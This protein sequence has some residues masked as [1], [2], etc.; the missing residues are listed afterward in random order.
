MN[1]KNYSN[2]EIKWLI[3]EWEELHGKKGTDGGRLLLLL[4]MADISRCMRRLSRKEREAVL[5]CGVLGIS[6]RSAAI[7]VGVSSPQTMN[8]RYRHGLASLA[9]HLNGTQPRT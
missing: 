8:N 1:M 7:L 6:T 2:R 9:R 3:E 4:K 5:L